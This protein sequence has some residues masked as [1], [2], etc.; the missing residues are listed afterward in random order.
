MPHGLD[1]VRPSR[2]RLRLVSAWFTGVIT[3]AIIGWVD[4]SSG[5][6]LRVFPLYYL[7]ISLLAWQAGR[8]GAV[9]GAALSAL[10]WAE[11]NLLAGLHFSYE[12]VWVAN[13]VFQGVSFAT[14]GY[15]I[16][17]LRAGMIRERAL[18][19]IDP[20]TGLLNRRAFQ[21]EAA[22]ILAL[23]RRKGRPATLAY[24]DLDDFKIVND[25]RG[26]RAGDDLLRKV[27]GLMRASIRPSDLCSRLGGD[28]FAILLSDA[29]SR[30]AQVAL[31]RV[32]FLLSED[33]ATNRPPVTATIGA[34]TFVTVPENLET[35]L[36][37]AD[38]TM[39]AAKAEG[40]NRL[41]LGVQSETEG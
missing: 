27:A 13:T 24:V 38:A 26:H 20:L 32:R 41:R 11:S 30:E 39:Y 34:V 10:V 1:A 23:C 3:I 12:G 9:I 40:K 6:E 19:R 22:S 18:S 4:F 35:M 14:V 25:T 33:T 7:P 28:E 16:A 36:S 2:R 29:D 17:S 37:R 5:T 21:E 31:E 8:A 15:L